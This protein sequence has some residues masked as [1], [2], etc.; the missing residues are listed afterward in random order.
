MR[1]QG[2]RDAPVPEQRPD[3]RRLVSDLEGSVARCR[4][5]WCWP[6]FSSILAFF[7]ALRRQVFAACTNTGSSPSA[8]DSPHFRQLRPPGGVGRRFVRLAHGPA[9]PE[10]LG[11]EAQRPPA[12]PG[13]DRIHGLH[14]PARPAGSRA[15]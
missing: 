5:N 9:V 11:P 2:D 7:G 4:A 14:Q 13:V 6:I 15:P 3:V 1:A 12:Q 10:A 8:P